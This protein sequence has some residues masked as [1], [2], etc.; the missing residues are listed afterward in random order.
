[1]KIS[2]FGKNDEKILGLE[3]S[4]STWRKGYDL[5]RY[6]EIR[7]DF[8]LQVIQLLLGCEIVIGEKG[9]WKINHN[10]S[11]LN[12]KDI[13]HVFQLVDEYLM[14]V[15]KPYIEGGSFRYQDFYV[16]DYSEGL[17]GKELRNEIML[18]SGSMLRL[19]DFVRLAHLGDLIKQKRRRTK[20]MW[21]GA[22]LGAVVLAFLSYK[23]YKYYK[24]KQEDDE[25]DYPYIDDDVDDSEA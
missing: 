9:K 21:A 23:G 1:M 5:N 7:T 3:K 17:T 11:L 13:I 18:V 22:S 2:V 15:E 4:I 8:N 12:R 19:H 25:F 16:N 10:S 14:F 20:M 24:K 6:R